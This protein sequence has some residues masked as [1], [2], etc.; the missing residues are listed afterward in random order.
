VGESRFVHAA[1]V[2]RGNAFHRDD[3]NPFFHALHKHDT[4]S[5]LLYIAEG[6]GTFVIDGV[7]YMAGEGT[8]L[9]YHRG[10]WH[11]EKSMRYPFKAIYFSF[12]NLQIKGLPPDYFLP[13]HRPPILQLGESHF[14]V[15]ELLYRCLAEFESVDLESHTLANLWLGIALVRLFRI[16]NEGMQEDHSHKPSRTAVLRARGYIEENYHREITLQM[17]A[18]ISHVSPYHLAHLFKEEMGTSPIQFL[19]HYRMEVAKRYLTTT[20]LP[21]KDVSE[22]TGY[23][24]ETSFHNIFKK[25]TGQ[26]P[27]QF[28]KSER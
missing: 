22:L 18:R 23:E 11:E 17:L 2:I 9:F 3:A 20:D 24:S 12:H 19:I 8:V 10:I 27:G 5:Q 21:L 15:G 16:A 25:I 6:E 7:P 1:R 28:R 14:E 13:A 26:T 4:V